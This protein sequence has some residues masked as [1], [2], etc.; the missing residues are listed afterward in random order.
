MCVPVR[1]G[2][3]FACMYVLNL[4]AYACCHVMLMDAWCTYV[5]YARHYILLH[6]LFLPRFVVVSHQITSLQNGSGNARPCWKQPA[7]TT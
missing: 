5:S 2:T 1:C 3:S 7:P 6:N 4:D